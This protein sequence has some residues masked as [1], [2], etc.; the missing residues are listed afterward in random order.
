MPKFEANHTGELDVNRPFTS[1]IHANFQE[2]L[3][4]FHSW[5]RIPSPAPIKTASGYWPPMG[6][7]WTP[8][9]FAASSQ[10]RHAPS[11]QN[12]TGM[13]AAP[14]MLAQGSNVPFAANRNV[15]LRL[16]PGAGGAGCQRT[17]DI[18]HFIH[19][20]SALHAL[21][22]PPKYI[23]TLIEL[24]RLAALSLAGGRDSETALA[25]GGVC[26]AESR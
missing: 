5:V 2:F 3:P 20:T 16:A 9:V 6:C 4:S 12:R 8:L 22:D 7:N 13:Q 14:V 10:I 1:K 19:W 23:E 11:P 25:T 26:P 24:D 18:P 17:P 21:A 15:P